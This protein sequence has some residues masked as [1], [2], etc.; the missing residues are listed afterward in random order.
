MAGTLAGASRLSF[1]IPVAAV[2]TVAL[3][4]LMQALIRTEL[5]PIAPREDRPHFVIAEYVVP[6]DPVRPHPDAIEDP[7]PPPEIPELDADRAD[8]DS[9]V[10]PVPFGPVVIDTP[11]G[12]GFDARD[13]AFVHD[14]GP[15]VR[16]PPTYP[17]QRL[18]AGDEGDCLVRFDVLGSGA[19]ANVRVLACDPGFERASIAAVERWRYNATDRVGPGEIALRG[20]TTQLEYRLDQ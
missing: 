12:E 4:M 14:P 7:V 15:I 6:Y 18:A 16:V 3:F 13:V 2:V 1:I 8:P 17:P 19:P 20:L 10:E 5:V 9:Q 11:G